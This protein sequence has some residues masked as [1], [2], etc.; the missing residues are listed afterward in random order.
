MTKESPELSDRELATLLLLSH[1]LRVPD[2]A[3]RHGG[4]HRA[5]LPPSAV[6]RTP[7][8]ARNNGRA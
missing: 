7:R 2:I 3:A 1:G 6:G 4:R 8:I 5:R